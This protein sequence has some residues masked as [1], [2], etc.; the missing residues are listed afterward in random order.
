M[1]A[2]VG[3]TVRMKK[4]PELTAVALVG[5]QNDGVTLANG[6]IDITDKD[7]GGYRTLMDTWGLRSL[8]VNVEGI[9]KDDELISIATSATGSVLLQ[10]YTLVIGNIGTF[11][12]DFFLNNLT[13]GA[14]TNEGVTFTAA[15]LSS[16][17]YTYTA[18]T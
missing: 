2:I 7:D 4:G 1:A 18:A 9:L 17:A 15:L 12:G 14:S 6:E 10:E 8:D 3:R 16:G 13:L 5:S 11:A